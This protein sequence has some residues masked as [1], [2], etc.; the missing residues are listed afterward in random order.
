MFPTPT[1]LTTLL[2][3]CPFDASDVRW[4]LTMVLVGVSPV[5]DDAEQLLVII[6]HLCV[7]FGATLIKFLAH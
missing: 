2:T 4:C 5:T 7:I 3:V 1:P 6:G